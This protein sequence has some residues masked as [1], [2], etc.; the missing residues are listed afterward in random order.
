MKETRL[1]TGSDDFEVG[2]PLAMVAKLVMMEEWRK[3]RR[4]EMI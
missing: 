3:Q 2:D 4:M 1:R